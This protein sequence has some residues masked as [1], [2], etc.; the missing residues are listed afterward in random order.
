MTSTS[1]N[2]PH[3]VNPYNS[4]SLKQGILTWVK[5]KERNF[6]YFFLLTY[7]KKEYTILNVERDLQ[8]LQS[9]LSNDIY[10]RKRNIDDPEQNV[11]FIGFIESHSDGSLHVHVL[12]E[13]FGQHARSEIYCHGKRYN[14]KRQKD[15]S[16]LITHHWIRLQHAKLLKQPHEF[17]DAIANKMKRM[18]KNKKLTKRI[19]QKIQRKNK[20]IMKAIR[21]NKMSTLKKTKPS[22]AIKINSSNMIY[23]KNKKYIKVIVRK[24]QEHRRAGLYEYFC[25]KVK[26]NL[27]AVSYTTLRTAP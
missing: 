7:A 25:K 5:N 18:K 6:R 21:G 12:L 11:S 27:E 17:F 15:I 16:K 13:S 10:G 3:Y 20:W 9:R 14:L 23:F 4:K 26:Y 8:N 19:K 24:I 22:N 2:N 1:N